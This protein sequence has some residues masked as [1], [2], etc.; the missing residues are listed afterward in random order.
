MAKYQV[1]WTKTAAEDLE[2]IIDY[3]SLDSKIRAKEQY[4]K[5]KAAALTLNKFPTKGRIVPE[6]KENNIE[7]YRELITSPW[8]LFYRIVQEKVFVLAL[9]DSR[10]NIEDILLAR[11]LR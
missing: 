8:R 11:H 5:I 1:F 6:L 3:I 9:I 7:K 10:R 4:Q 2:D